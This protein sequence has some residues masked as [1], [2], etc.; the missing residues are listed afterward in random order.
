MLTFN[1]KFSEDLTIEWFKDNESL[2]VNNDYMLIDGPDL[3]IFQVNEYRDFGNYRCGE[4]EYNI[5]KPPPISNLW[6]DPTIEWIKQL[7]NNYLT[8]QSDN[9]I[10]VIIIIGILSFVLIS[11]CYRVSKIYSTASVNYA[12]VKFIKKRINLQNKL[13]Q[14]KDQKKESAKNRTKLINEVSTTME[15]DDDD[16]YDERKPFIA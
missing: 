13:Q 5:I 11:F 2:I 7:F 1:C 14:L 6:T 10:M 12:K 16:Y 3:I 9:L 4:N 8:F 15:T